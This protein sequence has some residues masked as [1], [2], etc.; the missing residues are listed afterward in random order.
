MTSP[1]QPFGESRDFRD[2]LDRPPGW[3]EDYFS[4]NDPPRRRNAIC[5]GLPWGIPEARLPG[6]L[7]SGEVSRS[8]VH[9]FA[10]G[11]ATENCQQQA[12]TESETGSAQRDVHQALDFDS[13]T[14]QAHTDLSDEGHWV[15]QGHQVVLEPN[16]T[17]TNEDATSN[18]PTSVKAKS[19]CEE[20]FKAH[21]AISQHT[22]LTIIDLITN[23]ST[24]NL[25]ITGRQDCP[26]EVDRWYRQRRRENACCCLCHLGEGVEASSSWRNRSYTDECEVYVEWI[27][28]RAQYDAMPCDCLYID[29]DNDSGGEEGLGSSY[30][31]LF[32]DD[33]DVDSLSEL[34]GSDGEDH[35][36]GDDLKFTRS[37]KAGPSGA[38]GWRQS[39]RTP[40]MPESKLPGAYGAEARKVEALRH[41]NA[42]VS[43]AATPPE[44][45]NG[46]ADGKA[47]ESA[48]SSS[49]LPVARAQTRHQAH[50]ILQADQAE[51]NTPVSDYV[52]AARSD[53]RH[54]KVSTNPDKVDSAALPVPV[55]PCHQRMINFIS[56]CIA[57]TATVLVT[58]GKEVNEAVLESE[59]RLR[60]SLIRTRREQRQAMQDAIKA[61][62]LAKAVARGY[63][64]TVSQAE[65]ETPTTPTSTND[66]LEGHE[67][68]DDFL[69]WLATLEVYIILVFLITN[70]VEIIL[71]LLVMTVVA[72]W[73][74][75]RPSGSL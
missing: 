61:A 12:V 21:K 58:I 74:A 47:N 24:H 15:S 31:N 26:C 27:E 39:F 19:K 63:S 42:S 68:L 51:Q 71:V 22:E 72:S 4:F 56:T 65:D 54:A 67:E 70:L 34:S 46:S 33:D 25:Q 73:D 52:S 60:E 75:L 32:L 53:A 3:D 45:V 29:D 50:R 35:D 16:L 1:S 41:A 23:L 48:T 8:A 64:T 17:P 59:S 2:F 13:D 5:Y 14:E 36:N 28:E 20:P 9:H 10:L 43:Q 55:I 37:S 62:A 40:Q 30:D 6:P 7:A 44:I 57:A 18:A 49:V 11:A 38:S 69:L 66:E